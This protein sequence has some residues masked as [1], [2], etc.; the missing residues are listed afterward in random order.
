MNVGLQE[1][2]GT[3]LDTLDNIVRNLNKSGFVLI[4]YI[5]TIDNLPEKLCLSCKLSAQGWRL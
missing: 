4:L 2:N 1:I 3:R 5:I